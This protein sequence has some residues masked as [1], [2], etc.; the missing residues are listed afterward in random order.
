M[1]TKSKPRAKGGAAPGAPKPKIEP[2]KTPLLRR[3]WFR[4][5]TAV[6]LAVL[7]LWIALFVWGRVSRSSALRSYETKLFNAGR[8]FFQDIQQGVNSMQQAIADYKNGTMN[9]TALGVN[10]ATWEKDFR[11]AGLAISKLKPPSELKGAQFDLL[12][13]LAD[14]VGVA[15]FYVVVQKQSD[16]AASIPANLKTQKTAASNQLQ[17]LLQHVADAQS[18]AD[19]T[20]AQAMAAIN[21]LAAKWHVKAKNPFPPA[22][23]VIPPPGSSELPPNPL[24][25]P[26]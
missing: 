19:V 25:V 23:G 2:R 7:A 6:V 5:T 21:D 4:R 3:T 11:T 24:T 15:R 26:S 9:A 10:A 1:A 20:Y 17:L 22:P 14:Y 13:S 8:P 12:V 16:L 18:R